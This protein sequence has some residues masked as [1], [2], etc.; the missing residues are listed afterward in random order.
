MRVGQ[1]IDFVKDN[2]HPLKS[3]NTDLVGAWLTC[4][5]SLLKEDPYSWTVEETG[6]GPHQTMTYHI[7]GDQPVEIQ[8]QRIEFQ[9]FRRCWMDKAWCEENDEH[10][11]SYMKLFR[12]N[13][14]KFKTWIKE[15]KPCVL[16]RRGSRVAVIHP[17][18]PE[19]RKAKILA[20]L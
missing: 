6:S 19:A 15:Q 3:P 2:L 8:G 5:G 4:G 11:I 18:L 12:D 14:V 16:V 20:E 13:T 17:D 7:D 9:E 1:R 10:P